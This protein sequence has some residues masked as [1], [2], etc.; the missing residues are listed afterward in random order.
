MTEHQKQIQEHLVNKTLEAHLQSKAERG[1]VMC[2]LI[3]KSYFIEIL[4]KLCSFIKLYYQPFSQ[5]Y[6]LE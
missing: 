1:R 6:F 3:W 5:S 4:H 2:S